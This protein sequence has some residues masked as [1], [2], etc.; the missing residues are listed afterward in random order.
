MWWREHW[1]M[2]KIGCVFWAFVVVGVGMIESQPHTV[3]FVVVMCT[4]AYATQASTIFSV[5]RNQAFAS[6]IILIVP[7]VL[8]GVVVMMLITGTTLNVQSFM[9]AI[10]VLGIAG[11]DAILLIAYAERFRR[12]G[13]STVE[14]A[15]EA[16]SAR[17]R[18]LLMTVSA[19]VAGMMPLALG[20][21]E[22]GEQI[23]PLGR[24]V[25]GGLL[26]STLATM[27]VLPVI[28]AIFQAN[29]PKYSLSLDP[30]DPHSPN[31]EAEAR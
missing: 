9:G 15:W 20:F 26:A 12:E 3:F 30:D 11:A 25:I 14:A 5:D 16:G 27:F 17:L 7:A 22:G 29:A 6:V 2:E 19:M 8:S 21:G 23:A 31:Y 13:M 1:A 24:A 10:M 4:M 28:Y 18:A